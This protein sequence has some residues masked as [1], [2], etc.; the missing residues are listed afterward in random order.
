MLEASTDDAAEATQP[1][2]ILCNNTEYGPLQPSGPA[3]TA[4]TTL[5]RVAM[6]SRAL[7]PVTPRNR[8]KAIVALASDLQFAP[9][10]LILT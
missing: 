2:C 4:I 6:L 5:T 7:L 10:V 1:G 9:N 3:G 8:P